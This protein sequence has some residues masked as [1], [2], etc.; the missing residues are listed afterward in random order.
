MDLFDTHFHLPDEGDTAHYLDALPGEHRFRLFALGGSLNSS[1]RANAFAQTHS[2]VWCAC[3]VHPHDAEEF[4]GDVGPFRELLEQPRVRAVGEIG[5]DFYYDLS[6]RRRQMA[7]FEQF[8]ALALETNR[9][10]CVHCRDAEERTDAYVEAYAMLREFAAEAGPG[11]MILHC[12][13][14]TPGYLEKF[15]ELGAYIGVTGMVTFKKSDNIRDNLRRIPADRLLLETDSPYLAPVPYR[16]RTNHPAY[17]VEIAERTALEL[18]EAPAALAART[19]ANGL[20][21]FGIAE[22]EE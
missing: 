13:A 4:D 15:L 21:V 18:H 14:G 5:L 10:V 7:C 22:N 6:P 19:A 1:R 16:G 9:P 11:R 17:L 2:R 3:G 8:L 20:S 12:Y